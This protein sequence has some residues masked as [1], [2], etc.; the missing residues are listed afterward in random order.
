MSLEKKKFYQ[1]IDWGCPPNTKEVR[2]EISL[3]PSQ[4]VDNK[5]LLHDVSGKSGIKG[6]TL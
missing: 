1:A 4:Q 5:I 2:A 3:W 6:L